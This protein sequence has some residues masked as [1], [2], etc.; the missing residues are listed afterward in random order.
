MRP[1]LGEGMRERLWGTIGMVRLSQV[2]YVF[3]SGRLSK[4]D[5]MT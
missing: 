3:F 2:I 4:V 5:E 1:F